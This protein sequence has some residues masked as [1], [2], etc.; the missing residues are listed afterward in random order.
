[1]ICH[2]FCQFL[3]QNHLRSVR[4]SFQ[5]RSTKND[6][7][8]KCHGGVRPS[9]FSKLWPEEVS[10]YF[11]SNI[12]WNVADFLKKK[13][14]F[15]TLFQYAHSPSCHKY[16][17]CFESPGGQSSAVSLFFLSVSVFCASTP[18]KTPLTPC[19]LFILPDSKTGWTQTVFIFSLRAPSLS[20]MKTDKERRWNIR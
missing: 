6:L 10:S 16:A 2:H 12:I 14:Y 1:M 4:F 3:G 18:Q 17:R 15:L 8:V 11:I 7:E 20:V 9:N 19:F 5:T 13:A